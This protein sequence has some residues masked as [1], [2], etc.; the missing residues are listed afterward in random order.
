MSGNLNNA[1]CD[2]T[3][4]L[5][6]I[7]LPMTAIETASTMDKIVTQIK[8]RFKVSTI[9]PSSYFG[10]KTIIIRTVIQ[11][12]TLRDRSRGSVVLTILYLR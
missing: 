12:N 7:Q 5:Y 11:Q 2:R 3:E 8:T 9:S 4:N 6:T 1:L 10:H